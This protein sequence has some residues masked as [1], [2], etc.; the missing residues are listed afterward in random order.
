MIYLDNS[1]TTFPKPESVYLAVD[2]AQ[3]NLAVNIGRGHYNVASEA[4]AIVDETRAL[5]AQL[6]NANSSSDVVFTPS[7]TIAAN[8]IILG[9]EWDSYKNIYISPYEHNAIARPIELAK[10][11]YGFSL[12]IL[13]FD[14]SSYSIDVDK[15]QRMFAENP[16]DYIFLNHISNITG[17][18]LPV[19]IISTCAKEYNA[20]IIV[21]ASQ[22]IGLIE[23]NVKKLGIDYLIF[24][25]HKNLYS[26][27][28]V[29]GFVCNSN[30]SLVPVLAGGTGSDS[31]NLSMDN[32]LPTGF[33]VGSPNII[34]ICSLNAS[35][36]WLI[37]TGIEH[38]AKSKTVLMDNLIYGLR[39]KPIK[40]YLPESR[41]NHTSILSFNHNDYT[42]NEVGSILCNE[43]DIAVRTGYHC[44]PYIH[45][46]I[47]TKKFNG[48]VR[49]SFSYFNTEN[50][51]NEL[52]QVIS[53]I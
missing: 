19:D 26:S 31:L 5:I 39:E 18:I 7:A 24:A 9:L 17:I 46:I 38:I 42:S 50:D 45:D 48:T 12:F 22:S 13:P 33:E 53:N 30:T 11:Q 43:Y 41:I 25:G 51:I 52:L 16:P 44:V 28:G 36:K 10:N 47:D 14:H 6:V 3:R 27:F 35:L 2:N 20:T 15:M 34:A 1:A 40:L 49:I 32:S 29:G 23:T 4:T 37:D 21:D 8:E